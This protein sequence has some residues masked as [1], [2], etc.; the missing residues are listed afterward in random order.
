MLC[1]GHA[2]GIWMV[3]EKSAHLLSYSA[4]SICSSNM[5]YVYLEV[6]KAARARQFSLL[7]VAKPSLD[8]RE[9][10]YHCSMESLNLVQ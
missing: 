5:G 9:D 1:V 6:G 8:V 4:S 2:N 3:Q 7:L 10:S